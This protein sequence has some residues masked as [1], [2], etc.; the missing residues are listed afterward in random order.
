MGQINDSNSQQ[1]AS[2]IICFEGRFQES[3]FTEHCARLAAASKQMYVRDLPRN[4][5]AAASQFNRSAAD[6]ARCLP[7]MAGIFSM[8][9]CVFAGFFR[10]QVARHCSAPSAQCVAPEAARKPGL[11][12]CRSVAFRLALSTGTGHPEC[13][14]GC[15][16]SNSDQ[17]ASA[18]ISSVLALEVQITGRTAE[19]ASE[20]PHPYPGY[21]CCQPI[22]GYT[23][24]PRRI[25]Q[26]R[27]RHWPD[28]RGQLGRDRGA[29]NET[30]LIIG[31]DLK[32]ADAAML[33]ELVAR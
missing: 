29:A 31:I 17:L 7:A 20:H 18:W 10:G 15:R 8:N 27:H 9:W 28:N 33:P 26:T 23:S 24:H 5:F 30:G 32:M 13:F 11:Q 19:D 16:A 2:A 12:Q 6:S 4:P 1:L 14:V 22:V 25:A 3:R 21:E